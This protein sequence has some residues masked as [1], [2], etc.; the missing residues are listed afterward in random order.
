MHQYY[1]YI[2]MFAVRV[3]IKL[4]FYITKIN[5]QIHKLQITALY[6]TAMALTLE[7]L[8]DELRV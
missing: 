5:I 1:N 6:H 7:M 3:C 8:H 4:L 2:T